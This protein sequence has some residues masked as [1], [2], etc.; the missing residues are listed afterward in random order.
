MVVDVSVRL[1]YVVTWREISD[2]LKIQM[3]HSPAGRWCYR[4]L[5]G[6]VAL[7]GLVS[8][9]NLLIRGV[10]AVG[11]GVWKFFLIACLFLAAVRWLMALALLAYARHL[12]E[13]HV[14][15]DEDGI[16]TVSERH[17]NQTGWGFYGRSVEGRRVFVLLTPDVW[18]TGVLILP[19]RGLG[20]PQDSERLRS[21]ITRHLAAA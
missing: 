1:T 13:H 17:T 12:G 21:L 16:S 14:T 5:W 6:L 4:V 7:L 18:G 9:T 20:A 11:L 10:G 8:T 2:G 3:R 15:V 19:K